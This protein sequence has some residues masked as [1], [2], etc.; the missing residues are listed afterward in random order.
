MHTLSVVIPV[1]RGSTTLRGVVEELLSLPSPQRSPNGHEYK[2]VEVLLV[3]DNGP[4]ASDEVIRELVVESGLVRAIW[5][6]RNYGQHAATLAG[7][8]S[9]VGDWV[10]T[11]DEDG[12]QDPRDLGGM[13][14]AALSTRAQVVY[15][16]PLNPPPHGWFR[17]WSSRSAKRIVSVLTGAKTVTDFNSYR[18]ILGSIARGVA[19]YAGSG[20]YL[21]IALTWV[22]GRFTTAPTNL[23]SE[24]RPSG[25]SYRALASHFWR[26]VISGGTRPLRVVGILGVV[27][28]GLG[29]LLAIWIVVVK[30]ATGIDTQ[31]WASTVVILLVAAGA[32]LFSLAVIAEYIGVNVN[33]AMGKPA[34]F[35]TSD[36][37]AGPMK[38]DSPT[39]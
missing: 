17:N 29:L 25:Y 24:T 39:P 15:A 37:E 28:G 26:L 32:I 33:M 11:V 10:A 13:L 31:G 6:R 18:L 30:L 1:Y 21:D 2:I 23:R 8:A 5:L 4:D 19:A 27:Y 22:A 38:R 36:R 34:Y 16:K 3:D 9:S 20:A 7:M 12:Q 14:D 35:V